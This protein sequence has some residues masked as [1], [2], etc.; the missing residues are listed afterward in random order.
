V[1]ENVHMRRTVIV[2]ENHKPEAVGA[3][4]RHHST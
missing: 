1:S 2:R 4:D 3:V